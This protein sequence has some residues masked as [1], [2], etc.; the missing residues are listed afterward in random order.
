MKPF[1]IFFALVLAVC[2]AGAAKAQSRDFPDTLRLNPKIPLPSHLKNMLQQPSDYQS[3]RAQ[4]YSLRVL[5]AE[6]SPDNMPVS[7][8]DSSRH[9]SLRIKRLPQPQLVPDSR[10]Q[11]RPLLP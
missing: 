8:A 6:A 11:R 3:Y 7:K 9:Y 5:K 2:S 1:G 10:R 4:P